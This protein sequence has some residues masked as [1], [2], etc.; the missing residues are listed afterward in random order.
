M[1]F[2]EPLILVFQIEEIKKQDVPLSLNQLNKPF[3][4]ITV[5][6]I[7]S[8]VWNSEVAPILSYKPLSIVMAPVTQRNNTQQSSSNNE[9]KILHAD[10][11][12]YS[13]FS[14]LSIAII[15]TVTKNHIERK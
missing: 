4:N 2:L 7:L 9:Y 15:K 13:C 10:V 8:F 12:K 1:A 11:C 3:F 6:P 5:P 14:L